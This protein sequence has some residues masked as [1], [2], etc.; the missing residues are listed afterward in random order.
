MC[1][2]VTYYYNMYMY[3][4]NYLGEVANHVESIL[5]ILCHYVEEEGVC[6]IVEGLVVKE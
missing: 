4:G 3:T 1:V 6:V 5:V 2:Q